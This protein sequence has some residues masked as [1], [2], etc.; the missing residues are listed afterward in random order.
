M[1]SR[2]LVGAKLALKLLK[3]GAEAN[4]YLGEFMGSP[5]VFKR[6]IR[7]PY[8]VKELDWKIRE[9][10]TVHEAKL[11]HEAKVAGVPTP[12]VY[13]VDHQ[14][15]EL[16][17]QYVEGLRLKDF[18]ERNMGAEE[19]ER[20]CFQL[21]IYIGRLHSHG[22]I[23]GDLTT[24]NIILPPEG[25]LV[26]VDFGLGFHSESV[27][28]RGVDLHLLKQVFESHHLRW[29]KKCVE[30]VFEGYR[31]TVGEAEAQKVWRKMKEIEA[32]GRYVPP[33]ARLQA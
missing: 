7:K 6:R 9:S 20:K 32:R 3:K 13:F 8:R 30:A 26:F 4:L 5:A 18:L 25:R 15:T 16:V 29:A 14:R 27:E 10:R 12:L 19:V 23:H 28:D 11:L 17:L 22:L 33:E 24:S 2:S 31:N 1:A 21:G